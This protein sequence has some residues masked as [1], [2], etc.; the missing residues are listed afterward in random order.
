MKASTPSTCLIFNL[1]KTHSETDKGENQELFKFMA[2]QEM[3]NWF[4]ITKSS[5][6]QFYYNLIKTY[7][8]NW[9][10]VISIMG[11][12]VCKV[13]RTC[14]QVSGDAPLCNAHSTSW[15]ER[16]QKEKYIFKI[17][18][19]CTIK[20]MRYYQKVWENLNSTWEPNVSETFATVPFGNQYRN[21]R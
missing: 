21:N 1:I 16:K 19:Q 12:E 13:T 11:I 17:N 20:D 18:V 7:L 6:E 2:V 9:L 15:L 14:W 5:S 4:C 3:G 10:Y 8:E